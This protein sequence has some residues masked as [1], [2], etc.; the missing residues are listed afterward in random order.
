MKKLFTLLILLYTV[1][2]FAQQ[3]DNEWI[4]PSKAYYKFKI[5]SSGL[6]RI[7]QA[8]LAA[9][10]LDGAPA[11][12][13]QLWRNGKEVPLFTSAAS[14]ALP[15]NGYIEFWGEANDGKPDKALYRDP[16]YQHTDK[17]SL[18]SD[19]AAY[20]LT[21]NPAANQRFNNAPNNTAGNVL[22]PEPYFMYTAGKYFRNRINPGFAVVIGEYVYSSS[23]D[24]GEFWSSPVFTPASP[25]TDAMSALNVYPGGPDA[26]L[27]FGA[28]G[29]A[30]NTRNFQVKVN[31]S[32]VKDTVCNYFND[33]VTTAPIPLGSISGGTASVQFVNTSGTGTDRSV[34]S[35]YEL[36]YPRKFDFGGQTNFSFELGP[37]SNGYYLEITNF[38]NGSTAPVLYDLTYQQRYI[39]DIS[40]PGMVKFVLP[41]ATAARQLILV[42]EV[43]SNYTSIGGAAFRIT[44]F[45]D[46]NNVNN[47]G[48]YLIISNKL[49]Y[50]GANGSNPVDD[51]K[52]YRASADGG[53]YNAKVMDIDQL[54]D[55]FAFGINKDP[56]SVKNFLRFARAK[57]AVKPKFAFLIGRGVDYSDY[58]YYESNVYANQ[59]NLVPTFGWPASDN[60]LA[61]DDGA[62]S[63][64]LTYIGR[65]SAVLPAEVSDYLGK[66]KEYE[67]AQK[68]NANTIADRA[69]MK[70]IVK[71]TGASDNY[72]GTVLCNFMESYKQICEDTLIGGKVTVFCK[73][74]TS[75]VERLSSQ[76][77]TQLF[78]EGISLITYF[79]HSS[80][81]V[82]QFNIEP[83]ENYNNAGKYPI[84]SVNGCNAGD[85]FT[86]APLRITQNQKTLSETYML[87]KQRGGIAFIASTHF[88][89]VNYLNIYLNTMYTLMGKTDYGATIG[90]LTSDAGGQL[91]QIAGNG[92]FYA[93]LHA[94]EMTLNGDPALKPNF[95]AKPDYDM[96]S[97]Q[98]KINPQFISIAADKF[99]AEIKLYNLGKAIDDS[100]VVEVK[101]QYPDNTVETILRKKIRGVHYT[102][103][104][105]LNIPVVASRDKGLNKLIITVDADNAVQE[106]DEGNNT[107]TKEFYIYEDELRPVF[108]YNYS[109]V[110]KQN[111]KLYASTANPFSDIK[112]YVLE[113]DTTEGFNSPMK[114]SKTISSAGGLLEFDPGIGFTDSTVYYWRTTVAPAQGGVYRW[115]VS[116]FINLANSG[117]G[118]N[119]SHYYQHLGSGVK[120][121]S[122]NQNRK[123]EFGK[124]INTLFIHHGS[125]VTSASQEPLVAVAANGVDVAHNTCAFSSLVFNVFD[126]VTFKPMINTTT[127]GKGLYGSEANNCSGGREINFEFRYTDI[128][129]RTNI[130]NFMDNVIPG[131]AYVLVRTFLLDSVRFPSFPKAF[132]KDWKADTSVLGSNNSIYN[133][134]LQQGFIELDS[135]NR[136]RQFVFLYKKNDQADFAPKYKFTEGVY[137]NITL[138]AD[139]PTPDT[140]GFI[141]SPAF[142]PAKAWKQVHWRGSSLEPNSADNPSVSIVGVSASG[143]ESVI[144]TLD[145]NTQDYDISAVSAVQYP[146]IKLKMRNVDSVTLTP[147]QLRYWR[148]DYD[149]VPEGALIPNVYFKSKNPTKPVDSLDIGEPLNFGIAFKNISNSGFD[150]LKI[151]MYII[152]RN[153]VTRSIAL[154][155]AKP[156]IAG[157]S[158]RFDYSI[159]TKNYPGINTLY[160]D[161]N[162]DNDQPEQYHFN[163]FLFRNFYVRPDS[164]SPLL[165]VTFDNVHILNRDIVSAK[166]HIQIKLQD[167]SKYLLLND[168]S[169][170]KVQVRFPDNTIRSYQFGDSLRFT[171][172]G[173]GTDNS[174]TIDFF[175][176]FLKQL[177]PAGDEYQLIVFGKD[178]SGNKAGATEYKVVFRVIS[179][180]MISNLLNYPNPF[181]TSTAFVFTIT[182]SEVPQNMKIQI[183]TVT[184]KIVREITKEELGPLHIGRNITDYKWDGNDQFGQRLANGVYLY[185]FVTQLNGKKMDKY[186]V[187]T[188]IT[189]KFFNNGY[190]KMY[191]MR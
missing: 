45:I 135:F 188:D 97:S 37:N 16:A 90:K 98:V 111:L 181:T 94:E 186:K 129:S 43:A 44:N 34:A 17:I 120:D 137:D 136:Q 140:V 7:P 138:A 150:S 143:T 156:L 103:S 92:D 183:L 23:Y 121:I 53:G 56:L 163:N 144:V 40:A 78:N 179:K 155:R 42:S 67:H 96:E 171:P 141:T 52:T 187:E 47:Q 108:P 48:D 127:A 104:L 5:G 174:A 11:E 184:G 15:A 115:N 41:P 123:W 117:S 46:F 19:T 76:V 14:G 3:Y 83:P 22:P 126:P 154:P 130:I 65:L 161:F 173:T 110:N 68:Y 6:Y 2:A 114:I 125:W 73:T 185:R 95:Q 159:D 79:G 12:Q 165:D 109:I 87:A 13:F 63:T 146:Y 175:P 169:E 82:L 32:I 157:D 55:Q 86:F 31:G 191:L 148:V 139:C 70:N 122:M 30:L 132:V 128:T 142:G 51:Y 57:F 189:D 145:K 84:F 182:G 75:D 69:W 151:K 66:I 124:Q 64:A 168:T 9:I 71:V 119:Q 36:T 74:S 89:I 80:A 25:L 180:P 172:A 1:T 21:L 131:N 38:N 58:R 134:L 93:R 99:Q 18:I 190:G 20:F 10:G 176:A 101:R 105:L 4:N 72:L 112:Q 24:K 60:M 29:N 102:D 152:D 133:R 160:I 50:N 77:L 149:P 177:D 166:P 88:G 26:I 107:I 59:L 162:P 61:S 164:I 147:Y 116:S 118:F 153:N 49:L 158:I 85:F 62:G 81:T 35:F 106:M 91:L 28:V 167:N 100:I 113:I 27:K 170:I 54:V 178:R 33:L 8:S 39:G